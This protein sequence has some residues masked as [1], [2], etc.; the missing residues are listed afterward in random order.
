M[1]YSAIVKSGA[2]LAVVPA[3][4]AL[5]AAPALAHTGVDAHAGFA[6]GFGHPFGGLDHLLAMVAVGL[7]AIQLNQNGSRHGL[8]L[9]PLSFVAPM[10]LGFLSGYAGLPLPGVELGI[11]LSV[12]ALGL[13]V[14][15]AARPPL[16]VA[17]LF[18]A[19]AAIFHGHA[20]GA[21]MPADGI[22]AAYAG[23]M[24]L[25]TAL[26]HGAGIAAARLAQRVSLPVLT[27]A[28][29]AAVAVCGVVILVA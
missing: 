5:L 28:A 1:S 15:F 2:K 17:M 25:A 7:W 6:S 16:A 23:G 11:A 13:V 19:V 12:L 27:R 21:E 22:A 4:L 9:L 8:W 3:A 26:L 14:A 20:H 29:G 18:C 10:A 24:V